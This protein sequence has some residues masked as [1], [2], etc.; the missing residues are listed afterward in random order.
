M[1]T[2]IFF[3]QPCDT[4]VSLIFCQV[5]KQRLQEVIQLNLCLKIKMCPNGSEPKPV[6]PYCLNHHNWVKETNIYMHVCLLSR[7]VISDS[8]RPHGC[9]GS[10]VHGILQAR[11]LKW[12]TISFSRGSSWPR[13]RTYISWTAGRFL[14]IWATREAQICMYACIYI[15][16]CQGYGFSS[17]HVWMW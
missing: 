11:I 3:T 8:L 4:S 15:Y 13:D 6:L 9:K 10:S 16:I 5:T 14:T 7:S 1:S 12:V 17:S 2:Y